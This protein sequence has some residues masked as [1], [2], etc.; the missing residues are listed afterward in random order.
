MDDSTMMLVLEPSLDV[1]FR[2]MIRPCEIP[3]KVSVSHW[4]RC[5][6]CSPCLV[7]PET[8]E[9]RRAAC[10]SVSLAI[11]MLACVCVLLAG[12]VKRP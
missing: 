1:S 8:E 10:S 11:L 2:R 7:A 9:T 3:S 6:Q 5:G 12:Q 4:Q